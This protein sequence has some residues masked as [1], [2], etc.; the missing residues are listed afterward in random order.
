[1]K[2][3]DVFGAVLGRLGTRSMILATASLALA[4]FS[5][6]SAASAAC[7][8]EAI[9][10]AQHA[11]HLSDCRAWEMV[12]PLAKSNGDIVADGLTTIAAADGEAVSFNVRTP[13]GDA[14][15]SGQGGQTS[16]VAR[17]DASSW[18]SRAVTPMAN[19]E[20]LQTFFATT[21]LHWFSTDLRTAVLW[22]Y[23]LPGATDDIT[24]HNNIYVEDVATRGLRTVSY[25]ETEV[26]PFVFDLLNE[27]QWG[28]SDDAQHIAFVT[29]YQ[30][31]PQAS[32]GE[33]PS[34][35][36]WNNGV[37]SLAGILP[38]GSVPPGG[39]VGATEDPQKGYRREMSA[40]GSR[41]LF[42]SPA[43]GTQQLYQ[44]I[45]GERTVLISES[46]NPSFAGEPQEVHLQAATP[47]GKNVFFTTTSKLLE[48]D[49]NTGPDIYRWT[50]G[51]D[52][53]HEQN[54]TLITNTGD[55]P[56]DFIVGGAVVGVSDDGQIV[57]THSI[58]NKLSIWD[59]GSTKLITAKVPRPGEPS[60]Q[61]TAIASQPGYGRVSP[62]GGHL[63]FISNATT[64][65]GHGLTGE[66]TNAHWEVYVYSVEDATLRCASCPSGEATSDVR[67]IPEVTEPVIAVNNTAIRPEFL[68]DDGR[69]F[70]TSSEALVPNDTN[71]VA[72]AYQYDPATEEVKL[73]SSGKGKVPSAFLDASSS[74]DDVFIATRQRLTG[75][76][77]D[78][79]VD[80]YDVRQGGGFVEP[81]AAPG[82]CQGEGCQGGSAASPAGATVASASTGRGNLKQRR[83]P[84]CAK[85]KRKVRRNGKVGCVKR[86]GKHRRARANRRAGK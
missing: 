70:F 61:L 56:Q 46:E 26:E 8:N 60:Y 32:E 35:Y 31:L 47:D 40:D 16:Y 85:G 3:R 21:K 53:E 1:M 36:Q 76:D 51:P 52:A 11:N 55:M 14:I 9:R 39:S 86:H 18:T 38:D 17:R 10:N 48:A 43:E 81:E 59:H 58:S 44:R 68:A 27:H 19:P 74:G 82:A 25:R 54:L 41:L 20:A 5:A 80:V 15:G 73:L 37:L 4:A 77:T 23:D 2:A 83:H 24:R 84:S 42:A 72:D 78:E 69:V 22:A 65:G 34:I 71:G 79:L 45:D 64:D 57:Y 49:P 29:R 7:S 66:V 62:N 13:F 12:S 63:A 75:Y 67:V 30:R 50:D 33:V 6:P 28:M